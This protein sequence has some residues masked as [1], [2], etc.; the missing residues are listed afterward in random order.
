MTSGMNCQ[1]HCLE[2]VV[3]ELPILALQRL[4]ILDLAVA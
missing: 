4:L 1:K 3:F 2:L